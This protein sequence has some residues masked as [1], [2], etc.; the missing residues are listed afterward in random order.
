MPSET[1]NPSPVTSSITPAASSSV[2]WS[3]SQHLVIDGFQ[4]VLSSERG[5]WRSPAIEVKLNGD[6]VDE[7]VQRAVVRSPSRATDHCSKSVGAKERNRQKSI[8]RRPRRSAWYTD[9]AA[10]VATFLPRPGQQ[11]VG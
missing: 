10:A 2:A 4:I 3:D 7:T 8:S 9:W 5:G 11:I 1:A 6:R